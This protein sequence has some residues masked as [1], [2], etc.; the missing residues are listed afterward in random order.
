MENDA[1]Q[2]SELSKYQLIS[3]PKLDKFQVPVAMLQQMFEVKFPRNNADVCDT[4]QQRRRRY[5]AADVKASS[6][7][8]QRALGAH[9]LK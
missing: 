7:T 6:A 8:R 1:T 3:R 5:S 2:T 4:D 9:R